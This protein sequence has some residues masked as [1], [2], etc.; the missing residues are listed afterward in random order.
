MRIQGLEASLFSL[1]SAIGH[2]GTLLSAVIA[3]KVLNA[4]YRTHVQTLLVLSFS[5]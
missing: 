1:F 5:H 2:A 3:S 4:I